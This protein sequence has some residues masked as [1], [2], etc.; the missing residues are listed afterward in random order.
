MSKMKMP[1]CNSRIEHK[2]N[3]LVYLRVGGLYLTTR[4]STLESAQRH[5]KRVG[6]KATVIIQQIKTEISEEVVDE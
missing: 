3:F 6:K 2:T 5:A 4:H 1:I